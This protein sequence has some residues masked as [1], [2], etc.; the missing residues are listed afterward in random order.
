MKCIY[1]SNLTKSFDYYTKEAGILNSF[2]NLLHREKLTKYAVNGISFNIDEGEIV[3]FLG[4]NGA[5]K[6]TTLKVL[7]GILYPTGGEVNVMGYV[8]WERKT[9]FKKKFSII[10]G[11]KNQL[12]WDLPANESLYLNKC[13]YEIDDKEYRNTIAYLSELLDVKHVLDIQVRRLSLGERMKLEIIA[14]LL[15]KPKVIFL[16]EPT[17]GL[18]I[19]SQKR[20]REFLIHYNQETK[21]TIMLT[22]HYMKDIE[23]L[24]KRT[25]VINKGNKIYD[26]SIE[27]INSNFISKKILKIQTS[28]YIGKE[29]YE[30]MG[31]IKGYDGF[32]VTIEVDKKDVKSLS[33]DI[34]D[35]LPVMDFNL[36]DIPLEEEIEI[37]YKE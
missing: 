7:S 24:C 36:E 29:I 10:M 21:T 14:A 9:E 27:G 31:Q 2:K 3:G 34:L 23:D 1:V 25:I 18:D 19:I 17:I 32:N 8:P 26:G 15:H 28:E 22:S 33:K 4:P 12:W 11:Q 5:G 37:L 6:T 35:M 30:K 16:D 20:I 13:I